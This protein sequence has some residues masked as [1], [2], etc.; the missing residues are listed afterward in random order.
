[1]FTDQQS[2]IGTIVSATA[3]CSRYK[4][5]LNASFNNS[6]CS[7]VVK[8][9]SHFHIFRKSTIPFDVYLL[10]WIRHISMFIITIAIW[11]LLLFFV[12]NGVTTPRW[13]KFNGM[14]IR[15]KDR[16]RLNNAIWRCWHIECKFNM[17]LTTDIDN[18]YVYGLIFHTQLILR[19]QCWQKIKAKTDSICN[20][21]RLGLCWQRGKM[22][23]NL[24]P[25]WFVFHF[26]KVFYKYENKSKHIYIMT[27]MKYHH[28]SNDSPHNDF[29]FHKRP[30]F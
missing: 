27:Y 22:G 7:S 12:R 11:Q 1:M 19:S 14:N 10:A 17:W 16:I 5:V 23:S 24:V 26:V 29:D 8:L 28:Q 13:K 25:I 4:W 21:P 30:L 6:I 15:L 9:I 20:S 2:Y 3:G 18:H